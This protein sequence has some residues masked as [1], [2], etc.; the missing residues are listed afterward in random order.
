MTETCSLPDG[1]AEQPHATCQA[2]RRPDVRRPPRRRL[3]EPI[4]KREELDAELSE[5][6]LG[7]I[8]ERRSPKC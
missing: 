8:R 1:A 6:L 7:E 4:A 5:R 2:Q 3:K